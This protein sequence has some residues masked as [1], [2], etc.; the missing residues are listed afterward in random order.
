MDGNAYCELATVGSPGDTGY[1]ENTCVKTT[2]TGY[3]IN[4]R[5]TISADFTFHVTAA[6]FEMQTGDYIFWPNWN[7]THIDYTLKGSQS[8][9]GE[10]YTGVTGPTNVLMMPSQTFEW[11]SNGQEIH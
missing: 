1:R 7:G 11:N 2:G 4:E 5:C 8:S 6:R 10:F 9:P 3:G